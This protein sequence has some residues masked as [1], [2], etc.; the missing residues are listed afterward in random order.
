MLGAI[1]SDGAHR[2][3]GCILYALCFGE[4]P[5]AEASSLQ[6]LNAAYTIPTD[7]PQEEKRAV[8]T[9]SVQ[10]PGK[11]SREPSAY[12]PT[13][14]TRGR[15]VLRDATAGRGV[16]L[17]SVGAGVPEFIAVTVGASV[18]QRRLVPL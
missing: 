5:F 3:L 15:V 2:A 11:R 18:P 10:T 1:A 12:L 17:F 13:S 6:I 7:S 9:R 14:R 16:T 4:H 8:E